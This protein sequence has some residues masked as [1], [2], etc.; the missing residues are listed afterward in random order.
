MMRELVYN[1]NTVKVVPKSH[2]KKKDL[3]FF[4]SGCEL[5]HDYVVF[6]DASLK[7]LVIICGD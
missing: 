5:T 7:I 6:C 1:P 2:G 3:E 4:A